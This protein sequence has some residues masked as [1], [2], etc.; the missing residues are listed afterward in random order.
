M[1]RNRMPSMLHFISSL[2]PPFFV[3]LCHRL[4]FAFGSPP[5]GIFDIVMR[6][7]RY[8]RL[9]AKAA[10]T[11]LLIFPVAFE[12]QNV[13]S[14]YLREVFQGRVGSAVNIVEASD[15]VYEVKAFGGM[16]RGH[17][18]FDMGYCDGGEDIVELEDLTVFGF[19]D[20]EENGEM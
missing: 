14:L 15:V 1:I 4:P 18:S 19:D 9:G 2:L 13:A 16:M 8:V 12:S 20:D 7:E 5:R 10:D 11:W 17:Q 6:A 3:L